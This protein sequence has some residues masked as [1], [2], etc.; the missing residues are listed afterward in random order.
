MLQRHG[1]GRIY[2]DYDLFENLVDCKSWPERFEASHYAMGRPE[3]DSCPEFD[4]RWRHR[5]SGRKR[6]V[7]H[8]SGGGVVCTVGESILWDTGGK[9]QDKDQIRD[10]ENNM[11]ELAPSAD[12]RSGNLRFPMFW[13]NSAHT[14]MTMLC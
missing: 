8:R 13:W 5:I 7:V 9:G 2:Q 10:F 14:R 11:D 1:D 3:L 4:L 6:S 12:P